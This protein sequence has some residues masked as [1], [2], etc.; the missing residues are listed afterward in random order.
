M[1]KLFLLRLGVPLGGRFPGLFYRLA[2]LTGRLAWYA[3]PRTRER[4]VRNL[5]P[6]CG[7][8]ERRA[9]RASKE[10]FGHVSRY[11]VDLATMPRRDLASIER[12]YMRLVNGERGARLIEQPGPI[13]ALSAH[14]GN[15]ELAV[16]AFT[17]RGRP[18]VA[19]VQPLEPPE[20]AEYLLR[21]RSSAGG[22]FYEADIGGI[23]ACI[24][25]LKAGKLVAIMSDRDIQ[26]SGVCVEMCGRR[27]KLP[28][29]AFELARRTR[30][31]LLPI[32]CIRDGIDHQVAFIEEPYCVAKTADAEEDVRQAAQRW[33]GLLE[34][35]I[36]RYPGQWKILEDFWEAHAC[37]E[38]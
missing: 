17:H 4:V 38:G 13:I 30:A 36:G 3:M 26:G 33:A 1:L 21:L 27:V 19:L 25:A 29:G 8:N 20:L 23:R 15:P 28:R 2:G 18:F 14:T 37:G 31:T 24:E 34:Q 10:V 7:G 22:T 5:L 12:D 6:F 16:Q 35:H 9:R 11:Y 32:L